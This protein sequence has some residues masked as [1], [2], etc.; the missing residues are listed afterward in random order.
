MN[1][2]RATIMLLDL[3]KI[4]FVNTWA[5]QEALLRA[6]KFILPNWISVPSKLTSAKF[7]QTLS[8]RI[9]IIYRPLMEDCVFKLENISITKTTAVYR[10]S[11]DFF[12]YGLF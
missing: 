10:L 1:D 11:R 9:T 6:V 7:I 5:A 4:A 12:L 8:K 2:K 3:E